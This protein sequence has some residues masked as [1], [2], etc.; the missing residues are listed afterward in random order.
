MK[1]NNQKL[2]WKENTFWTDGYLVYSVG[3][4]GPE[5]IRNYIVNQGA[6]LKPCSP[7]A[8]DDWDFSYLVI[9]FKINIYL[10]KKNVLLYK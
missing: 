10:I 5:T 7:T 8:K 4:A 9:K 3:D 2:F 6:R 1:K